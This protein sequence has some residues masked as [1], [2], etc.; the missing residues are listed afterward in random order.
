MPRHDAGTGGCAG[1]AIG[2]DGAAQNAAMQ[3][4]A[5]RGHAV[6]GGLNGGGGGGAGFV[7]KGDAAP[8]SGGDG[9]DALPSMQLANLSVSVPAGGGGGAKAAGTGGSAG[10]GGGGSVEITAG[11]DISIPMGISA[12]GG[13]A[14]DVSAGGGGGGGAGGAILVRSGGTATLGTLSVARGEPG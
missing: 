12:N 3:D 8:S 4:C 13:K 1:G 5:G 7:I 11:G 10:G 14:A 6:A 9:G 2:A